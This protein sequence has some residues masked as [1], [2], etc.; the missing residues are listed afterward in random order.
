MQ[1]ATV[2]NL[3]RIK[4]ATSAAYTPVADDNGKSLAARATYTDNI[5]TDLDTDDDECSM[6]R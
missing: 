2:T 5:V 6:T 1:M 4:G 3:C